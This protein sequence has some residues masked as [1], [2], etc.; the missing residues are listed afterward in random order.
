MITNPASILYKKMESSL[1]QD[2]PEEAGGGFFSRGGLQQ[3]VTNNEP[4]ERVR[5]YFKRIRKAR[6]D[7]NNARTNL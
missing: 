2:L 4:A 5:N 7:F 3:N 6:E 1:T